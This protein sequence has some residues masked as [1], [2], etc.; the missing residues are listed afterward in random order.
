MLTMTYSSFQFVIT[1]QIL[2][3]WV[4]ISHGRCLSQSDFLGSVDGL[5]GSAN[6][7]QSLL[8]IE[9]KIYSYVQNKIEENSND[10]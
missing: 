6:M 8:K 3:I 10:L 4:E 2:I 7:I 1:C 9:Q 5:E